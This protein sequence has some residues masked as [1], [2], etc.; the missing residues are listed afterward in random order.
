MVEMNLGDGF[1]RRKQIQ[2]EFKVWLNRLSLSGREESKFSVLK[3]GD[4]EEQA[5]PGSSKKYGRNFTIEECLEKLKDL[6][7]EDKILSKRISLTNQQAK[8]IALDLD[9]NEVELTIPELIVLKNDIAPKLEEIEQNIPQQAK[10]VEI[11]KEVKNYSIKWREIKTIVSRTREIS[12]KGL[13]RDVDVIKGYNV[14]EVIDYGY[15]ER[16][17]LERK[18]DLRAWL[19]RLK[20]AI[21]EANKTLLIKI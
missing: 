11:I 5:M 6:I 18:D 19:N 8:A 13:Q 1:S 21:N 10:N 3:L 7:E 14:R 16:K 9:G 4:S 12:S 20:Q 15:P 2:N 17:L